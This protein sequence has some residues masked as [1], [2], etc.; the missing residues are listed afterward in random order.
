M[1]YIDRLEIEIG[2]KAIKQFLPMQKGD[3][4]ATAADTSSLF[5]Y[6]E[7][8]PNTSIEKGI[9]KFVEWYVNEYKNI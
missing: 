3:V 7:Y 2:K 9:K 5:K 6:I 4:K 1:N 8:C